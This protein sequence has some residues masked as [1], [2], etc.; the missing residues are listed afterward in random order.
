M[1]SLWTSLV[2]QE[3]NIKSMMRFLFQGKVILFIVI[4][5]VSAIFYFQSKELKHETLPIVTTAKV[6]TSDFSDAITF[7][8]VV[9]PYEEVDIS[10]RTSGVISSM[11]VS[12]GDR[13]DEGVLL[14]ELDGNTDKTTNN[15]LQN[16]VLAI[17]QTSDAVKELYDERIK[18]V[19]ENL[20]LVK[21]SGNAS[22]SMF[23]NSKAVS[24][25]TNV[26]ILSTKTSDTLGDIL[27]MRNGVRNYKSSIFYENLGAT[28]FGT[29]SIAEDSLIEYQVLEKEYQNFFNKNILNKNPTQETVEQG[30]VLSKALSENAKHMLS[31]AY[32]ML[33]YTIA[34]ESLSKDQ[35]EVYK[36]NITTLGTENELML[37]SVR[38]IES[39]I[40]QSELALSTLKKE[41]NSKL[42][43]IQ[44]QKTQLEGQ[45]MVNNTLIEN[46]S[47][48]APFSGVITSKALDVGTVVGFGT[49]LY[50]LVNDDIVK[51]TVGVP[52]SIVHTFSQGGDVLILTEG[53][54]SE[55]L[56]AKIT[57]IYPAADPKNNKVTVEIEV[58]NSEHLIKVGSIVKVSLFN[59]KIEGVVTVPKEALI[60]RYGSKF[61]F[62]VEN[63]TVTKKIVTVGE[64]NDKDIEIVSGISF[65]DVVVKEGGYYLRNKD[66][67]KIATSTLYVKQ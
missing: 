33:K 29:R 27:S 63:G 25:I 32:S 44:A 13:V 43:E 51:I 17:D 1:R 15:S 14:F 45:V 47:S 67:V 7:V 41:K 22:S 58:D 3:N 62:V 9:K 16:N 21:Q 30:L 28:N 18:T 10:A 35:I 48:H 19:E 36:A 37:S 6:F 40:T 46:S 5:L 4:I 64:E 2:F 20:S 52:D 23:D 38:G 66:K 26:A 61:V 24:L 57:K 60:S 50:H 54:S 11:N 55:P 65:G 31:S 59:K 56:T 39:E 42:L 49:Q 12:V 53:K 34:S 8:G